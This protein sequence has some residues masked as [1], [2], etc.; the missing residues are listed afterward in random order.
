MPKL[1][2]PTCSVLESK[3][4]LPAPSSATEARRPLR[5]LCRSFEFRFQP[6]RGAFETTND[7]ACPIHIFH[8]TLHRP[9]FW[10]ACCEA[11][12]ITRLVCELEHLGTMGCL[13]RVLDL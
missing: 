12:E 8:A 4:P 3:N 11:F 2:R 7:I 10:R 9:V 6:G 1:T 13:V 5:F